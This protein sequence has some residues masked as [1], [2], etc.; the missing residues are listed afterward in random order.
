MTRTIVIT[1]R[2]L[3]VLRLA[4]LDDNYIAERLDITIPTVKEYFKRI[5]TKLRCGNR[6]QAIIKAIR[7]CLVKPEQFVLVETKRNDDD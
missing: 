6:R 2:E 5:Y 7:L 4:A 3:Q 1:Q